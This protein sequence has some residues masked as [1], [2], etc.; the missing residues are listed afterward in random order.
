MIIR[1]LGFRVLSFRVLGFRV[2]GFAVG[3]GLAIGAAHAGPLKTPIPHARGAAEPMQIRVV[4]D[5][6]GQCWKTRYMERAGDAD[7]GLYN[8]YYRTGPSVDLGFA[9]AGNSAWLW[10][11]IPKPLNAY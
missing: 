8:G 10:N 3:T 7:R 1:V 2:L 5:Q 9:P 6:N 4:C 11:W